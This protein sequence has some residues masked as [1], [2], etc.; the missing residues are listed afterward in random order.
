MDH[1]K[2][3]INVV[4]PGLCKTNLLRDASAMLRF[5]LSIAKLIAGRSSEEGSRTLLHGL[6]AGEES[7]GKYL[8]E[9]EIKE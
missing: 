4:N 8:S 7:H 6:A 9:C 2:I 5:N 1:S 3:I